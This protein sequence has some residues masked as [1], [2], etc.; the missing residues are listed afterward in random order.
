MQ[1][2]DVR[3]YYRKHASIYD[4]TR[5]TFLFGRERAVRRL[6]LK[7]EDHVLECGCGTGLNFGLMK[8]E[9]VSDR[10]MLVGL[11]FSEAMLK[12][13]AGRIARFGW[14]GI[15]LVEGAADEVVLAR[16][17]D[18]ILFCYSLTM[19]YD[20]ERALDNAHTHLRRGGRLVVHDFDRFGRWGPVG[21]MIRWVQR[22]NHVDT[23]RPY[24]EKIDALF[25]NVKVERWLGGYHFT[26]VAVKQ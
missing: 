6:G 18:A 8:R 2:G 3:D 25:G 20:W 14:E 5:W 1:R 9:L 21:G 26:A 11:D 12:K 7:S 15:E 13:A 23:S 17:F 10:S 4:A 16:T 22:S 19:I 24:V